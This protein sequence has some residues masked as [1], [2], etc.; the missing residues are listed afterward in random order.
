MQL[1]VM[2]AFDIFTFEN[3]Y[4]FLTFLG[5]HS[6]L[7][8]SVAMVMKTFDQGIKLKHIVTLYRG[9]SATEFLVVF[10]IVFKVK[11]GSFSMR[12]SI[13][14]YVLPY[15]TIQSYIFFVSLLYSRT[16]CMPP[17]I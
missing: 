11:N 16:L 13:F 17:C 8:P 10:Y 4:R 1:G 14:L 5:S 2:L 12:P 9:R 7:G 3:E 15:A 6:G